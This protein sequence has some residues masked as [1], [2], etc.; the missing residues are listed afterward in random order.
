MIATRQAT[1]MWHLFALF[2]AATAFAIV[3]PWPA[4]GLTLLARRWAY[5]RQC[6][7]ERLLIL[8]P[9][10]SFYPF[11]GA[12]L[13]AIAAV[14]SVFIVLYLGLQASRVWFQPAV[15]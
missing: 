8:C 14:F 12:Y 9:V 2:I 1:T 11:V 5:I 3:S 13:I 6:G 4:P 7:D 10:S 15:E